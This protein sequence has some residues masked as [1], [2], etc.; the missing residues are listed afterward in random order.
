MNTKGKRKKKKTIAINLKGKIVVQEN[1]KDKGNMIATLIKK[2]DSLPSL[3]NQNKQTMITSFNFNIPYPTLFC[4]TFSFLSL[5]KFLSIP[6][7]I[8]NQKN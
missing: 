6:N 3:V 1:E 7:Q 2:W 4:P 5:F 8:T